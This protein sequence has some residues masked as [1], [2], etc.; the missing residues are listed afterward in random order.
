MADEELQRTTT[1]EVA[2]RLVL[3]DDPSLDRVRVT[4]A[5]DLS[6]A[7][8]RALP[9]DERRSL[10]LIVSEALSCLVADPEVWLP[11][12]LVMESNQKIEV[13]MRID[14]GTL[15]ETVQATRRRGFEY[16]MSQRDDVLALRKELTDG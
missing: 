1:I 14:T 11:A 13:V 4:Q 7:A 9:S 5:E 15:R 6:L 8:W 2:S 16:K 10:V 12:S 3:D